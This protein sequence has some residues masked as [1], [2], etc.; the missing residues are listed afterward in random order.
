[1]N[2]NISIVN[3]NIWIT[4]LF[5]QKGMY[6]SFYDFLSPLVYY[7]KTGALLIAGYFI[8]WKVPEERVVNTVMVAL[9]HE[10]IHRTRAR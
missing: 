8:I 9:S 2:Y 3:D 1:M 5:G 4:F 10:S 6:H 7:P